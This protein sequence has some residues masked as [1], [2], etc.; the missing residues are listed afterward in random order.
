MHG[1]NLKLVCCLVYGNYIQVKSLFFSSFPLFDSVMV[2]CF[3][4]FIYV[5]QNITQ[6]EDGRYTVKH[7]LCILIETD[8][9]SSLSMV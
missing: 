2:T 9:S 7:S 6:S 3:D 1:G 4:R 8:L 5:L